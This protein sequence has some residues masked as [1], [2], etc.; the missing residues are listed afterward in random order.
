MSWKWNLCSLAILNDFLNLTFHKKNILRETFLNY[1]SF[2]TFLLISASSSLPDFNFCS[3]W[4]FLFPIFSSAK[5]NFHEKVFQFVTFP[6]GKFPPQIACQSRKFQFFLFTF[7]GKRIFVSL[8]IAKQFSALLFP[9]LISFK[10]GFSDCLFM[11]S[12]SA[13]NA[14]TRPALELDSRTYLLNGFINITDRESTRWKLFFFFSFFFS[15]LFS[16]FI[17]S[18]FC[19]AR[20][21]SFS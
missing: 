3:E 5:K 14:L 7:L 16:V 10:K 20:F 9:T 12:H 13:K 11:N 6:R 18:S 15:R 1:F 17:F 4:K 8:F 21:R 19:R 2:R